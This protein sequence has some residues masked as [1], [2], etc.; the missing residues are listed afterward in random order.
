MLYSVSW[1]NFKD[2]SKYCCS[3]KN[4]KKY[5][6]LGVLHQATTWGHSSPKIDASRYYQWFLLV[7]KNLYKFISWGSLAR[8]GVFTFITD[9]NMKFCFLPFFFPLIFEFYRELICGLDGNHK[10]G[11]IL[12]MVFVLVVI[13]RWSSLIKQVVHYMSS[14][15]F[16]WRRRR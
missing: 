7:E 8:L 5:S 9:S 12:R 4:T 11:Y 13:C 2:I 15:G 1:D 14:T 3:S 6:R 16:F 10:T